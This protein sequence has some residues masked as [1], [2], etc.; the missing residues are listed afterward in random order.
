MP[1]QFSKDTIIKELEGILKAFQERLMRV[2]TG[3]V[4]PALI[5]DIKLTYQGFEMRLKELGSIR[6]EGPRTLVVEP[7]D[8]E[9]I[10]DIERALVAPTV[11]LNPQIKGSSIYLNF[12]SITQE[13]RERLIKEL[14]EMKEETRIKI[15]HI[16]DNWWE[17]IQNAQHQGDVR[18]DEKF[19][20]KDEL[21]KLVDAYNTKVDESEERKIKSMM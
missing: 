11:G 5:E 19:K 21:Q 7:W 13:I 9:S 12:P 18:E 17:Q 2:H 4:N 10:G 1:F 20:F 8:K 3:Q 16:R 14:K 15:R 6:L